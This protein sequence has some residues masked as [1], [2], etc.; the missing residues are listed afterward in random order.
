MNKDNVGA[1]YKV[2]LEYPR[3]LHNL[4]KHLPLA[5]EH[6]IYKLCTILYNKKNNIVHYTNLSFYLNMA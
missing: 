3:E 5:P 4:H 1:I 2:D 6:F